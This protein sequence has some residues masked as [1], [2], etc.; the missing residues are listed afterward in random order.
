MARV[1][2]N[3]SP[4]R[5]RRSRG[6]GHGVRC[7]G[8]GVGGE[9]DAPGVAGSGVACS[10]VASIEGTHREFEARC[11]G[12]DFFSRFSVVIGGNLDKPRLGL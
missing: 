9:D 10:G 4:E 1:S 8:S 5:A 7:S 3:S 2:A 6:E 11:S 12:A